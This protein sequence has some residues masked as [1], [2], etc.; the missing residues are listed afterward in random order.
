MLSALYGAWAARAGDRKGALKLLEDGY[1]AFAH[2][3]F[4]QILEYRRDRFPE[5]PIAGPFFANM[6]GFL[7][8][9]LTGFPRLQIDDGDPQTWA[10]DLVV[11]P[12]GWTAIEID[13][14]FIRGSS[15]RLVA[16]QGERAQLTPA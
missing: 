9:L 13:R 2:D 10:S 1:G 5:Q 12:Q 11:L 15:M 14:L 4:L 8:S 16:R 3:R 6:G 7:M